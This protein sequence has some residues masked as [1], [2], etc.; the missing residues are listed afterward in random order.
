MFIVKSS[1]ESVNVKRKVRISPTSK[2]ENP[3]IYNS[4]YQEGEGLGTDEDDRK[5]EGVKCQRMCEP[6]SC[7]R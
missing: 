5:E 3:L 6:R 4:P 1:K 2:V 7:S